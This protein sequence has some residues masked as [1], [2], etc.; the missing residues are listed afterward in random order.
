MITKINMIKKHN[1]IVLGIVLLISATLIIPTAKAD[2]A[3]RIEIDEI[4]S[5]RN[6][7]I[8]YPG[9]NEKYLLYVATGCG[10]FEKGQSVE[11]IVRGSLNSSNDIIKAD[12]L[13]KCAIEQADLFTHKLYVQEVF[14]ENKKAYVLDENGQQYY[15]NYGSYCSAIAGYKKTYVYAFQAGDI[16]SRSDRIIL[17]N[18]DGQCSIYYLKKTTTVETV[19]TKSNPDLVPTTVTNVKAY[20][21]N[22]SVFL[23]WRSARDDKG[24]SHYIISYSKYPLS[25]KNVP[26]EDMPNRI[27]SKPTHYNVTDL[28]NDQP[29][30][31]Y[32]LAMDTAGNVSSDWSEEVQGIPKAS[33]LTGKTAGESNEMDLKI[34]NENANSFFIEWH[35]IS[36]RRQTVILDTDG[37][38]ELSWTDYSKSYIRILKRSHREGKP[39]TLKVRAYGSYGVVEEEINFDF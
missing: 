6:I 13:H 19:K 32:V 20:P 1:C 23:T 34:S 38:R 14:G 29:Y 12:S 10:T 15:I 4:V 11:L 27:I 8:T 16:L 22:G 3:Q 31:F 30:Y 35:P 39:L 24:I 25:T 21:R 28:E 17:P 33:F 26:L 9:D 2:F 36:G 18:K 37:K 5:R 7:V